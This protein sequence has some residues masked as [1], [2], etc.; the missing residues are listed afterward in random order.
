MVQAEEEKWQVPGIPLPEHTDKISTNQRKNET[1]TQT[2]NP[3][4]TRRSLLILIADWSETYRALEDHSNKAKD[5]SCASSDWP[6][7]CSYPVSPIGQQKIITRYLSLDTNKT[8]NTL[9]L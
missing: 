6:R 7:D 9:M 3:F 4:L 2:H 5:V 8:R 1:P